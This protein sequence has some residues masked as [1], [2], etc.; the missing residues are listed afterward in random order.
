[1]KWLDNIPL[2]MLAIAAVFLATAPFG[3][4]PHLW[5]KLQMLAAGNLAKPIDIFDLFMHGI[6]LLL[7]GVRLLRMAMA[8]FTG[9]IDPSSD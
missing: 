5:Q 8:K 4:E 1:M 7:L 2:P 3:S 6:P 9:E